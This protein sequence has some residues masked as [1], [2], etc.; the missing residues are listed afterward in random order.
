MT[1]SQHTDSAAPILV[2]GYGSTLRGDD[3]AGPLVAE[4]VAEWGRTD[5][6]ALAAHQ[7][8]PELAETLAGARLV[9]FVDA[10][11][12][13]ETGEVRAEPLEPAD[14]APTLGH[15]GNPRALLA[16][17]RALYGRC[18]EA[19]L[20]AIPA[21]DLGFGDKLSPVAERGVAAALEEVR[22][23]ISRKDAKAQRKAHQ[24]TETQRHRGCTE[25]FDS[26][27]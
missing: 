25:D 23:L 10:R 20:I 22:R 16:L 1:E 8:T 15:V 6:R 24:T 11:H 12:G 27:Y 2:I 17:A 4:K 9:V 5:V 26:G 13:S 18:P 21:P 3:A 14:A 19:W 7:L